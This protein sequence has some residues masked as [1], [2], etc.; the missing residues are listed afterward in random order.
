MLGRLRDCR[1]SLRPMLSDEVRYT[2]KM[3]RFQLPEKS[4]KPQYV[5]L[6]TITMMWK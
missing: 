3:C 1:T 2:R 4:C 6:L 5:L